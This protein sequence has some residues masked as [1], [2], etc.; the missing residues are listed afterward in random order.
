MKWDD[1]PS[2]QM[3]GTL[4]YYEVEHWKLEDP[5]NKTTVKVYSAS[6]KEITGLEIYTIYCYQVHGVLASGIHGNK[7]D[8]VCNSTDES[9][10]GLFQHDQIKSIHFLFLI[11]ILLNYLIFA[12]AYQ[13]PTG[14]CVNGICDKSPRMY[15]ESAAKIRQTGII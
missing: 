13:I 1:I 2:D 6:Q 9:G 14:N 4:G 10:R 15:V 11:K 12:I 3:T 7:S 5:E 8:A